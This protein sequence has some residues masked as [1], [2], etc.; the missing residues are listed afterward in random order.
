M[1]FFDL[2]SF[3]RLGQKSLKNFVNTLVETLTYTPKGHFEINGPLVASLPLSSPP[4]FKRVFLS[5]IF[6]AIFSETSLTFLSLKAR[7]NA[8]NWVNSKQ[9][10]HSNQ[11]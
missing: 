5:Q 10:L 4:S 1:D 2:T 11:G 7:L 6:A 3:K 8:I 9:N